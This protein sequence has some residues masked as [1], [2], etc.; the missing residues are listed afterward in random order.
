MIFSNEKF[1]QKISDVWRRSTHEGRHYVLPALHDFIHKGPNGEHVCLVFD[2]MGYHL[3]N[4]AFHFKGKRLPV[5]SVKSVKSI[6]R[7]VLLGLDFLHT[8]CG[9]IHTGMTANHK[10]KNR[11]LTY[12]IDLQPS[13][14]I[15]ELEDP[16][17]TIS[18]YLSENAPEIDEKGTLLR[19]S[20]QR[21]FCLR[22]AIFIPG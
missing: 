4:Q 9:I 12:G 6:A 22:L 16:E 7:Q 3:G 1:C 8:E 19:E 20:Y 21:H 2:V 14:I 11:G 17:K 15:M 10:S 18:Q 5:K 13:N